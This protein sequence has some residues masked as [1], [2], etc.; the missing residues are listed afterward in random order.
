[1][2][3]R[4]KGGGGQEAWFR[5]SERSICSMKY[6]VNIKKSYVDLKKADVDFGKSYVD[7]LGGR[8]SE[9]RTL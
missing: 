1:M 4:T 8:R 2:E 6:D 5:K 7:L 3:G 9:C